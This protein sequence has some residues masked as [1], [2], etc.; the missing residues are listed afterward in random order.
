MSIV[1][2]VF[3]LLGGVLDRKRHYLTPWPRF[4]MVGVWN[5][6]S[7]SHRSKIIPHAWYRAYLISHFKTP[8][9]TFVE[10]MFPVKNVSDETPNKH[11]LESNRVLFKPPTVKI[12]WAVQPVH[13]S[14]KK[15]NRKVRRAHIWHL[16]R[17]PLCGVYTC[18]WSDGQSVDVSVF[19][20][21][22]R[23]YSR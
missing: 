4:V 20:P 16:C 18:G 3:R 9:E 8:I 12:G 6:L 15:N 10:G 19:H 1:W 14:K 17:R 7:V 23:R 21:H 22:V 5:V 13:L 11:L 2:L